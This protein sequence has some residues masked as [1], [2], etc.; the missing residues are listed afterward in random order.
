EGEGRTEHAQCAT[1]GRFEVPGPASGVPA[2]LRKAVC[3]GLAPKPS[4]RWPSMDVLLAELS[5]DRESMWKRGIVAA[6]VIGSVGLALL[7]GQRDTNPEPERCTFDAAI[8]ETWTPADQARVRDVFEASGLPVERL[9][10]TIRDL[11]AY[12]DQIVAG[13]TAACED[14]YVT[15]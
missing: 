1:Q 14:R 10:W 13:Y 6:G 3:R 9:E 15:Q 11:G 5:R 2:W 4:D 8:V 12:A 7:F